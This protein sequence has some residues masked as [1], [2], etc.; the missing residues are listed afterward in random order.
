MLGCSFPNEFER[1]QGRTVVRPY[2][3]MARKQNGSYNA[4][5]S[6]QTPI[7]HLVVNSTH[8]TTVRSAHWHCPNTTVA[9][10][11]LGPEN[12]MAATMQVL[13]FKRR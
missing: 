7:V 11:L 13:A 10:R 5:I 4:S 1:Y 12:K 8:P 6:V 2:V 9:L 3:G